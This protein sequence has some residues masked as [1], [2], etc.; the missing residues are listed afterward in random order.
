MTA[1]LRKN[2]SSTAKITRLTSARCSHDSSLMP[3]RLYPISAETLCGRRSPPAPQLPSV[4]C[5]Q[6][7][8]SH[9]VPVRFLQRSLPLGWRSH[10]KSNTPRGCSP[11]HSTGLWDMHHEG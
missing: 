5:R 8:P 7:H 6:S 11:P 10:K 1:P 4:S 9:H 2:V 3:Y